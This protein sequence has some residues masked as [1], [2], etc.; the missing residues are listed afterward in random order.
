MRGHV[1]IFIDGVVAPQDLQLHIR[2]KQ[3]LNAQLTLF[4]RRFAFIF[5]SLFRIVFGGLVLPLVDNGPV[6]GAESLPRVF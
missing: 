4:Q 6:L 1:C 5:P 2:V 3:V